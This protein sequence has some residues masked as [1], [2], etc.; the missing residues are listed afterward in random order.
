MIMATSVELGAKGRLVIPAQVRHDAGVAIGQTLVA[1]ADGAGRI[2]LE[3]PDAVQRRV[4]AAAPM[5]S[6]GVDSVAD[7]RELRD[8]DR[9]TADGAAARRASARPG[10]D[11]DDEVGVALLGALGL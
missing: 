4:W 3:T 8:D 6:D 11:R 10:D 2:V 1:S 5:A 7:I 9:R